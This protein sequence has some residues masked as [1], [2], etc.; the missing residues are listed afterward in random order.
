MA[1]R[2]WS[3][4]PMPAA[5]APKMT[6]RWFRSGVPQT[7]TAEIAAASAMAPVPCISSLK[8]QMRSRYFSRMRRPL[9]GAK[10]S[11]CS[12]AFGNSRSPLRRKR[13]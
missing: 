3:A 10:S 8:V 6:T 5:P 4:I 7:R 9:P 2:I 13:R 12:S 11:H 1:S